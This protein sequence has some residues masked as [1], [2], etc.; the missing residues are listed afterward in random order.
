M[1]VGLGRTPGR[2]SNMCGLQSQHWSVNVITAR[3]LQ[4][5]TPEDLDLLDRWPRRWTARESQ[6]LIW[7]WYVDR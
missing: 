7:L 4:R 5:L 3:E 1:D 6:Q 2:V